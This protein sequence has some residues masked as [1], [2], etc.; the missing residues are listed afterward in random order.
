MSAMLQ[1]MK[2]Q[3]TIQNRTEMHSSVR[4]ATELL[5]QEIGQAGKISLPGPVT[6][7]GALLT[8]G[9]QTVVVSSAAGMFNGEQLVIDAGTNQE[10]VTVT[11]VDLT[12]NTITAAFNNTHLAN[13]PV[14][15][16]GAFASG[17][18]PPAPGYTNGSTGTV[19][20]LYGDINGD[21]NMMYVEY[22]CDTTSGNLYRNV[23]SFTAAAKPQVTSGMIL[24]NNI[25]PNP[26]GVYEYTR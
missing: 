17:V 6:L 19:L 8:T 20:K 23:M 10:T 3:G 7:T 4:N 15:V 25:V 1:M 21:G 22:T 14:N 13:V 16:R 18:V 24:L 11:N 12:A 9:T 26:G 5:S 2:T